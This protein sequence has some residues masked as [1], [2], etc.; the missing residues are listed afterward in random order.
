MSIDIAYPYQIN[1]YGQTPMRLTSFIFLYY[2][3]KLFE[4]NFVLSMI[5]LCNFL[6]SFNIHKKC[7]VFDTT[8]KGLFYDHIAISLWVL[9]IS[10][11]LYFSDTPLT[12]KTYAVIFAMLT[13]C[14]SKLRKF[15]EFRHPFRD[16]MHCS[17]HIFGILCT[18]L[19]V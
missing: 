8:C 7:M 9:Y 16:M 11:L 2:S 5:L 3:S 1:I 14:I 4:T 10:Y 13:V 12:N 6:T 15:I 18:S 19:L 17:T